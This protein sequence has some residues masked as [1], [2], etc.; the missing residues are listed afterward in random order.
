MTFKV[1]SFLSNIYHDC[2]TWT[3][4]KLLANEES[5]VRIWL[6]YRVFVVAAEHEVHHG[7]EAE[8]CEELLG[9]LPRVGGADGDLDIWRR[10]S[11]KTYKFT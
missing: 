9:A 2:F 7:L 1:H 6:R 10:E 3:H 11:V 8:L 5:V 4:A